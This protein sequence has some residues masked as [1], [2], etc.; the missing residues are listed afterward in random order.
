MVSVTF[1]GTG[2]SVIP[3][4]SN[5]S[6]NEYVPT[7]SVPVEPERINPS[8]SIDASKKAPAGENRTEAFG[9]GAPAARA[10]QLEEELGE[11]VFVE[12]PEVGQSFNVTDEVGT[13][14]EIMSP[15]D[16][17]QAVFQYLVKQ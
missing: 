7:G 16:N 4:S 14:D 17:L 5:S 11:I 9:S 8:E 12:L 6:A 10:R 3:S 2:S 13:I 15:D 1:S